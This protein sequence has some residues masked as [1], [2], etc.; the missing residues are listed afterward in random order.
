MQ[1]NQVFQSVRDILL[2]GYRISVSTLT[3]GLH[4]L[5]VKNGRGGAPRLAR[6]PSPINAEPSGQLYSSFLFRYLSFLS[7]IRSCEGFI[8]FALP[9]LELSI[10]AHLRLEDATIQQTCRPTLSNSKN[11]RFE[12]RRSKYAVGPDLAR[13]QEPTHKQLSS[14]HLWLDNFQSEPFNLTHS[15]I[16]TAPPTDITRIADFRRPNSRVPAP[17]EPA[18]R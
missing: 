15:F 1:E 13:P 9:H 5:A 17:S 8:C 4:N 2:V 18:S 3:R 12:A 6:H 11:F 16:Q 14:E 7:P 10:C